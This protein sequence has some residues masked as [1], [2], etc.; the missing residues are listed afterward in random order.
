MFTKHDTIPYAPALPGIDR[1][2]L[3][4]GAH[5]LMTEFRLKAGCTLPAHAHPQEQ[6]GYLVSGRMR[7]RIG[8]EEREL[9]PGDS[10]SIPG[11]AEHGAT[12]VEDSVALEVFSP[13]R[14]DYLP[15]N[16]ARQGALPAKPESA[17]G[18][19]LPAIARATAAD[20]AA[21]HELQRLA[22]RSEAELCGDWNIP[23]L[24][25]PLAATERALAEMVVLKATAAGGRIVG[26]VRG[27]MVGGTCQVGRL[28]VHPESQGHGLGTRLM[29][30]LEAALPQAKRFELFTGERSVRNLHLYAKLGYRAFRT[31]PL[32]PQV[33]VV[34]LE[35]TRA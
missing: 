10:W 14:E 23:P 13:V 16:E 19:P 27:R 33:T 29:Q 26:A 25:E 6:T 4:H 32:S 2:T 24:V 9:A 3:C 31:E 7:L 35:K 1:R 21:I 34:F 5:T 18:Q 20:A 15:Q 17:G 30:A 28:I 22:Y 8:P 11:G 12:I